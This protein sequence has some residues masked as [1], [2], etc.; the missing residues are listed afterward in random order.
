MR[1]PCQKLHTVIVV[2]DIGGPEPQYLVLLSIDFGPI[3]GFVGFAFGNLAVLDDALFSVLEDDEADGFIGGALSDDFCGY[4]EV[5]CEGI[6]YEGGICDADEAVVYAVG[7]DVFNAS[8][9]EISEDAVGDERQVQA[10][11]PI[12]RDGDLSINIEQ[13][14]ERKGW[15]R[16]FGF[17]FHDDFTIVCETGENSLLKDNDILLLPINPQYQSGR[18]LSIQKSFYCGESPP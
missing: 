17:L 3:D 4:R 15:R 10:S 9:L 12:R 14:E 5:V 8:F 7:V 6:A 11:I 1:C 13:R 16:Y 18:L 2:D